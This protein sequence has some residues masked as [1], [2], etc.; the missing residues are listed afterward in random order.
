M[1]EV[2]ASGTVTGASDAVTNALGT[3][4][5]DTAL[6]AVLRRIIDGGER[7]VKQ[8]ERTRCRIATANGVQTLSVPVSYDHSRLSHNEVTTADMTI[9]D[10][11]NWRHQH[12]NALASAYGESPFFDYY[13]DDIRPF[14]EKT[15]NNGV[16]KWD[17]LYEFNLAITKKMLE[18]LQFKHLLRGL[19]NLGTLGNPRESLENPRQNLGNPRG[20]LDNLESLE[21]LE[22][23][24]LI[25]GNPRP[26][27]QVFRQRHGFLEDLSI[28]D[29]LFNEGNEALLYI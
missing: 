13:A 10:H 29:L 6:D 18:L 20:T 16:A 14:F 5:D 3:V 9:S 7:F 8:T 15:D 22:N 24:S 21:V 2:E 1:T 26:Y 17:N 11:G 12:W 4:A 23:P 25:L 28:L 27:Y 19:G